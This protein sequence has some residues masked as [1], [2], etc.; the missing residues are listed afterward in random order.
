[1]CSVVKATVKSVSNKIGPGKLITKGDA[2]E[3]VPVVLYL[4]LTVPE[5]PPSFK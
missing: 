3:A 4:N 1:M 5:A 2:P